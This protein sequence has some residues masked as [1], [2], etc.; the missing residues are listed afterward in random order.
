MSDVGMANRS[1]ILETNRLRLRLFEQ[2]DVEQLHLLY[3][4]PEVMRYMGGTRTWEQAEE[5]I[6]AFAQQYAKTGFT[7]WAAQQKSDGQ[8]VGRVGLFFLDKTEEVE[9]GYM[10]AKPHW[11]KGF[12]TEA[13]AACLDLAFRR[14]ALESI[15]AIA[16]P[17]NAASLQIIQKLGF[18]FVREDR[19]YDTDVLYHRLER[20]AW[21]AANASQNIHIRRATIEDALAISNLIRPLA[22]RYI[23]HEFTPQGA[24]NLLASLDA[25][26]IEGYL[27][28]TFEYHLAEAHGSVVGVVGVRENSHLYHLFV[29]DDY[30]GHGLARRLWHV[31]R[32]ACRQA[33]NLGRF[34]V[35]SSSF[36]VGMYHKFGFIETGPPQTKNGVTSIPMKLTDEMAQLR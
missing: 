13:S 11:G 10:L 20:E 35:N 5:H 28:S 16:V 12:A 18:K 8:F 14:L 6:Q 30:R 29:A 15:A 19:Y 9:L 33:G 1:P 27:A 21:L 34:T 17:Q 3:S 2:S 36:A 32:D 26:A 7:L 22:Q 4:D 31:A 24:A 23:A 25:A